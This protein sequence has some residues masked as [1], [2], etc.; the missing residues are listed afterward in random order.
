VVVAALDKI[1][2]TECGSGCKREG[3]KNDALVD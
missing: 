1:A 3:E 2:V